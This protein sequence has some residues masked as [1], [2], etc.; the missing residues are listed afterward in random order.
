MGGKGGSST[1]VN[2]P[3]PYRVAQ[4]DFQYNRLGQF[5]PASNLQFFAPGQQIP[6]GLIQQTQ[7]M[8]QGFTPQAQQFFGQSG[9]QAGGGGEGAGKQGPPG[10]AMGTQQP[11]LNFGPGKNFGDAGMQAGMQ[12][13]AQTAPSDQFRPSAG[14][15]LGLAQ[16]GQA[17]R[18]A[19]GGFSNLGS[20]TATA[21]QT[22]APALLGLE[23]ARTTIDANTLANVLGLQQQVSQ[24]LPNLPTGLD[25]AGLPSGKLGTNLLQGGV[26]S[27]INLGG[28]PQGGTP[29]NAG[30]LLSTLP[31]SAED[32]R[33]RTEQAM[34]QRGLEPL[35]RA[36]GRQIETIE[37]RLANQ[38]LALGGEAASRV[39]SDFGREQNQ[40]L[41]N[42]ALESVLMGG[43]EASR[44]I[45]D[46]LGIT[47][48]AGGILGQAFQQ[49]EAQR[50]GRV[51][52]QFG[53]ADLANTATQL[54]AGL[55]AQ[56][57]GQ[58]EQQRQGRLQEQ[59]Q[60]AN[61][62]Q[63]A[64]L[65]PLNLLQAQLGMQQVGVPP[66]QSFLGTSPTGVTDAFGLNMAGQTA[67][68]QA[69]AQMKGSKLGGAAQLGAAGITAL[70]D[71]RLKTDIEQVGQLDSGI[72]YY[73][74]TYL[75]GEPGFGFMADEVSHV[76]GAVVNVDGIDFVNYE[77]VFAHG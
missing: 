1:T 5:T 69:N 56:G 60:S 75:W 61:L 14:G 55:Q 24:N 27:G 73:R 31:G 9:K 30:A 36:F 22:L 43:Q 35:E 21:V 42:L 33:S 19:Q 51:G 23:N 50:A 16:A 52:E 53:Q 44:S 68:A 58:A 2:S 3:D 57:F 67:N 63:N 29:L 40:A 11:A 10:P 17:A 37:Q 20:G 32:V 15:L 25:T 62:A 18:Q 71:R 38:G 48:Q 4:A 66:V 7:F 65:L 70:S 34:F 39:L 74:F 28:A 47:G 59:V 76:P 12:P 54:R 64:A 41:Q 26:Q 8:P 72:P 77:R 45:A 49:A 6:Q 46:Q 13:S